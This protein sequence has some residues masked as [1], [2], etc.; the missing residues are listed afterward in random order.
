M[1]L[2]M[3]STRGSVHQSVNSVYQCR[4]STF[5]LYGISHFS[6]HPT[7]LPSPPSPTAPELCLLCPCR[8]LI[9]SSAHFPAVDHV[10]PLLPKQKA[11]PPL[12]HHSVSMFSLP[13]CH[14]IGQ[15]TVDTAGYEFFI[16]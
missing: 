3:V 9:C 1:A 6:N 2:L 12:R 15:C 13:P 5:P 11:L 14:I 4:L 7:T 10:S 8:S 16:F